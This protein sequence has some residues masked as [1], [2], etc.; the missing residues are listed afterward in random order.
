MT[1]STPDP[2]TPNSSRPLRSSKA[3]SLPSKLNNA[4]SAGISSP[5]TDGRIGSAAFVERRLRAFAAQHGLANATFDG[6]IKY[7]VFRDRRLIRPEL[8]IAV[9]DSHTTTGGA[10]AAIALDA[11]VLQ[12]APL[13]FD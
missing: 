4:A 9:T 6:D 1:L 11:G 13:F 8:L 12:H 2:T 10:S 5:I 7:Q 3:I